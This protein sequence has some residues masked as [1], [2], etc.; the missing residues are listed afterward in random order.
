MSNTVGKTLK[1]T[2][3]EHAYLSEKCLHVRMFILNLALCIVFL[4]YKAI[5]FITISVIPP[6]FYHDKIVSLGGTEMAVDS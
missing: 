4:I 5:W 3:E 2:L 1:A 6:Q